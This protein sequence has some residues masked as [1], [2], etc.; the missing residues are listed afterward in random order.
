MRGDSPR[1]RLETSSQGGP[2]FREH[3]AHH[4]GEGELSIDRQ[5]QEELSQAVREAFDAAR[6]QLE[7]HAREQRHSVKLHEPAAVG[8]VVRLEPQEGYGFL[9][10]DDGREIYFHRNSVLGDAFDQLSLGTKVR[11]AEENGEKGPQ[12]SSLLILG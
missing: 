4:P 11:F 5:H 12:A 6:R 1:A 2:F 10:S 7:D 3:S 8:H 9:E